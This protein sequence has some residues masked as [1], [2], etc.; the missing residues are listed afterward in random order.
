MSGKISLLIMLTLLL[1]LSACVPTIIP[2]RAISTTTGF[3]LDSI[4]NPLAI[5]VEPNGR[6]S[7]VWLEQGDFEKYLVFYRTVLGEAQQVLS[8]RDDNAHVPDIAVTDNGNAHLVWYSGSGE[9]HYCYAAIPADGSGSLSCTSLYSGGLPPGIL[10]IRVIARGN[11]IYVVYPTRQ[12][13]YY[14]QLTPLLNTEGWVGKYTVGTSLDALDLA[15]DSDGYLHVIWVQY[16]D[17]SFTIL[18]NSN[19]SVTPGRDMNQLRYLGYYD[20]QGDIAIATAGTPQKVYIVKKFTDPDPLIGDRLFISSCVASGCPSITE[21]EIILDSTKRPWLIW[22]ISAIGIGS[23]VYIVFTADNGSITYSEVF[24]DVYGDIYP[25]G[26]ITT[27]NYQKVELKLVAG[28]GIPIA[29]WRKFTMSCHAD[30]AYVWDT[31]N[32][33]RQV[34]TSNCNNHYGADMA[35]NQDW[36]AGVWAAPISTSNPRVVPWMS[37]NGYV[38]SLPLVRK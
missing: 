21:S 11:Y 33:V 3:N 10:T 36:V 35:A 14:K 34:F 16:S 31:F 28:G 4:G 25:P 9:S 29:G 2:A 1:G 22:D 6:K 13:I 26:Q 32:G 15:I 8:L 23:S 12:G 38:S 5:A 24:L 20:P 18:Y 30:N 37:A 17:S 7:L 19:A 27:T